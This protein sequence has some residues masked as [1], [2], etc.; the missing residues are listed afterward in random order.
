ME[1]PLLHPGSTTLEL[2]LLQGEHKSSY[3]WEGQLLAQTFRTRRLDWSLITALIERWR[4][5]THTFHLSIGE[6]T[7]TLQDVEVLYG[8][9]VDGHPVALSNAIRENTGLQYLEMLQRLTGFQPPDETA[10]IGASHMQLTPVRQH[11]EAMHADITDYTP[12]LHIYRYTR[13]LLLL[14]F[15]GVLF[16]N[17]SGNLVRLRSLLHLE[18]LDDLYHYSRG[19]A[20]LGYLYR[21]MCR[22]SMGT[23]RDVAEFLSL[24]QGFV[25]FAGGHTGNWPKSVPP[26]GTV[27]AAVYREG[28]TALHEYGR[29]VNDLASQTLRRSRVDE[30]LGYQ[31]DYVVPEQYHRG[32][33]VEPERG[34]RGRRA[35]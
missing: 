15:G 32:L 34:R 30:H 13:L 10:L 16:L 29:Q 27:D 6:A 8:L 11:L 28:A 19:A 1:V 17:T 14:M 21:Q 12:E 33:A 5:E 20:I 25:G 9:P 24:L 23:Q 7:I 35:P 26:T 4:P 3:I 2:L 31:A 18:R 22:A